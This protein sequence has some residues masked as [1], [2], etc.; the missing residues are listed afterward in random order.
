MK[1]EFEWSESGL[2]ILSYMKLM[3]NKFGHENLSRIVEHE[4]LGNNKC[5][6]QNC[7]YCN[8]FKYPA[9]N[10]T[11]DLPELLTITTESQERVPVNMW[12]KDEDEYLESLNNLDIRQIEHLFPGRTYIAIQQRRTKLKRQPKVYLKVYSI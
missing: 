12:S 11:C 9:L 2:R 7:A 6:K 3:V 8:Y 10:Y 4:L 5:F 1:E